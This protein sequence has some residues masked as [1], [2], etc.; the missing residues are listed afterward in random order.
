MEFKKNTKYFWH[1]III[2]LFIC[3][4]ITFLLYSLKKENYPLIS[5]ASLSWFLKVINP[6]IYGP[7]IFVLLCFG[8]VGYPFIAWSKRIFGNYLWMLAPVFGFAF[9][10]LWILL[11]YIGFSFAVSVIVALTVV[12]IAYGVNL[13]FGKLKCDIPY[14]ELFYISIIS[15]LG[16]V[17]HMY[18]Y[19]QLGLTTYSGTGNNDMFY[20]SCRVESIIE[21]P[22]SARLPYLE[23]NERGKLYRTSII[24]SKKLNFVVGTEFVQ[25]TIAKIP[26]LNAVKSFPVLIGLSFL[27]SLWGVYLTARKGLFLSS[28]TS[29]LSISLLALS[30]FYFFI[31]QNGFLHH[32]CG[33]VCLIPV[34]PCFA[35]AF[36]KKKWSALIIG[37]VFLAAVY[38]Q[39]YLILPL[40]V[41]IAVA[42]GI[43]ALF[44]FVVKWLYRQIIK[45]NIHL[46]VK[47]L[48]VGIS[49]VGI[50]VCAFASFS[51]ALKQVVAKIPY[52]FS[53]YAKITISE[54][55][56]IQPRLA[57]NRNSIGIIQQLGVSEALLILIAV[58]VVL[59]FIKNIF[60]KDKYTRYS[61]FALVSVVSF[62]GYA[63]Y[64]T[65]NNNHYAELKFWSYVYPFI[66]IIPAAGIMWL[67]ERGLFIRIRAFLLLYILIALFTVA[68]INLSICATLNKNHAKHFGTFVD[69]E[70]MEMPGLFNEVPKNKTV[71]LGPMNTWDIAWAT[72]YG[73]NNEVTTKQ[74]PPFYYYPKG[75]NGRLSLLDSW[76]YQITTNTYSDKKLIE[77]AGRFN[78]YEF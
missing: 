9:W 19:S 53:Q 8:I 28:A 29:L 4:F 77:K 52:G 54:L 46:I 71:L 48:F 3:A 49:A 70:R 63:F 14:R 72:Y 39:Y 1:N 36:I 64:L 31:P 12:L 21:K 42:P 55:F 41:M 45:L 22:M 65:R 34:F 61:F 78:L 11:S 7:S 47:C 74:I 69:S 59:A 10:S 60:F 66:I 24:A 33:V 75:K 6:K 35:Q 23:E 51:F 2:A 62:L 50:T 32:I 26:G 73:R 20:Y 17:L 44:F 18:P 56:G 27:L 13:F 40:A 38:V 68:A 5:A 57:L 67:T 25:A 37:I 16:L 43:I 15:I 58:F 76:E 30:P